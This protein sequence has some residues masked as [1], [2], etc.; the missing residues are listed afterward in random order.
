MICPRG[1]FF[2]YLNSQFPDIKFYSFLGVF[3]NLKQKGRLISSISS[4][5]IEICGDKFPSASSCDHIQTHPYFYGRSE[6]ISKVYCKH[7]IKILFSV[8]K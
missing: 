6:R 5:G 2:D 3:V 7:N 4:Y 8:F 1:S